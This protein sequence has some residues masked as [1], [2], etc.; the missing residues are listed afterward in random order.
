[1]WNEKSLN[2]NK[3]IMFVKF[4]LS[5]YNITR[6]SVKWKVCL[7]Y[8]SGSYIIYLYTMYNWLTCVVEVMYLNGDTRYEC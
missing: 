5:K 2:I 6:A 1:M 8:L 7:L 4:E 3:I